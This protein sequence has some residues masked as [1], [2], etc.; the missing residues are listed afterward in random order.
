MAVTYKSFV[1]QIREKH[2]LPDNLPDNTV[3]DYGKKAYPGVSVDMSSMPNIPDV[4]DSPN[5]LGHL[6]RLGASADFAPEWL[7]HGY[8]NSLQGVTEKYMTG[9]LPFELED[10]WE[11]LNI[12]EQ[13]LSMIAS[14]TMPMDLMTML[15]GGAI[16]RIAVGSGKALTKGLVQ[17]GATDL[18]KKGIRRRI[19]E[20]GRKIGMK[21]A[22]QLA[23]DMVSGAAAE[24]INL[25]IYEGA[26]AGIEAS[27]QNKYNPQYKNTPINIL[28]EIGNGFTHGMTTGGILGLTGGFMGNKFAR[29][30]AAKSRYPNISMT[31]TKEFEKA[32][33]WYGKSG[34]WSFDPVGTGTLSLITA[35]QR[36]YDGDFQW[37]DLGRDLIV[38]SAF[39]YGTKKKHQALNKIVE[40]SGIKGWINKGVEEYKSDYKK[41]KESL[42]EELKYE[43]SIIDTFNEK[44]DRAE[45]Q[46]NK[47]QARVYRGVSEEL[48]SGRALEISKEIQKAQE[49]EGWMQRYSDLSKWYGG[50]EKVFDDIRTK[51]LKK[52]SKDTDRLLEVVDE[53][54]VLMAELDAIIT[55]GI[56]AGRYDKMDALGTLKKKYGFTKSELESIREDVTQISKD[57]FGELGERETSKVKDHQWYSD[58]IRLDKNLMKTFDLK[59]KD[60]AEMPLERLKDI[61]T[62]GQEATEGK[63]QVEAQLAAAKEG[64][65]LVVNKKPKDLDI[66]T[67]EYKTMVKEL[68]AIRSGKDKASPSWK[69]IRDVFTRGFRKKKGEP[70]KLWLEGV[71][72]FNLVALK[73][74]LQRGAEGKQ[75]SSKAEHVSKFLNYLGKLNKDVDTLTFADLLNYVSRRRV[76]LEGKAVSPTEMSA[77]SQF[78]K[79]ITSP[80]EG[81]FNKKLSFIGKESI[82]EATNKKLKAGTEFAVEG[83]RKEA[84]EIGQRLSK[85][86]AK[87]K[88]SEGYSLVAE[89]MAKLGIRDIEVSDIT[90]KQLKKDN[91]GRDYLDLKPSEIITD[92][93]TGEV[94]KKIGTAKADTIRRYVYV[95]KE[96][97]DRLNAFFEAGNKL[98]KKHYSTVGKKITKSKNKQRKQLDLRSR[99]ETEALIENPSV[100]EQLN[101]VLGHD[102]SRIGSGYRKMS[103]EKAIEIQVKLHKDGTLGVKTPKI[104]ETVKVK[105]KLGLEKEKPLNINEIDTP[106]KSVKYWEQ[107]QARVKERLKTATTESR[108]ETLQGQKLE[109]GMKLSA[110]KKL[111]EY[112]K[113]I[114]KAK[115]GKTKQN[116]IIERDKVIK[117]LGLQNVLKDVKKPEKTTP[118]DKTGEPSTP[119]ESQHEKALR[120]LNEGQQKHQRLYEENRDPRQKKIASEKDV[121]KKALKGSWALKGEAESLIKNYIKIHQDYAKRLKTDKEFGKKE[122]VGNIEYH[123]TWVKDYKEMLNVLK[124]GDSRDLQY[125]LED[126]DKL[127]IAD[128]RKKILQDAHIVQRDIGIGERQ[129]G[130]KEQYKKR[131]Q[132]DVKDVLGEDGVTSLS[133]LDTS[134]IIDYINHIQKSTSKENSNIKESLRSM[135]QRAQEAADEAQLVSAERADILKTINP[136][137]EGDFGSKYMNRET[138]KEYRAIVE[139]MAMNK[140]KPSTWS[141]NAM[142]M[143]GESFLKFP[144]RFKRTF[145]PA[146]SILK[147][148]GGKYGKKIADTLL[149]YDVV[150][151]LYRGKI[152]QAMY[153]VGRLESSFKVGNRHMLRFRDKSLRKDL[154]AEEKQFIKRMETKRTP[155]NTAKLIVDKTYNAYWNLIPNVIRKSGGRANVE[156]IEAYLGRKYLQDY[157][158]HKVNPLLLEV[159]ADRNEIVK[160]PFWKKK[161]NEEM[162][163]FARREAK[164]QGFSKEKDAFKYDQ[165]IRDIKLDPK[166][167][168]KVKSD[169]VSFF[170]KPMHQLDNPNLRERGVTLGRYTEILTPSGRIKK[171]KSYNETLEGTFE[172]YGIG[173]SKYLAALKFFPE[174]TSLGREFGLQNVRSDLFDMVSRKGK[175]SLNKNWYDYTAELIE[176]HLGF[177]SRLKRSY[178]EKDNRRMGVF[179]TTSAA[180]GLATPTAGLKNMFLGMTQTM[181]KYGFMNTINASMKFF[182]AQERLMARRK[183]WYQY[184]TKENVFEATESYFQEIPVFGKSL[185]MD[186]MFW[187]MTKSEGFNRFVAGKAGEL[188]F[189]ELLN[190]YKGVKGITNLSKKSAERELKDVLKFSKEELNHM[191]ENSLEYLYSKDNSGNMNWLINKAGHYGH[192]STQGGTAPVLLPLWMSRKAAKPFTLFY[193]IAASTTHNTYNNF[194]KPLIKDGNIMPIIKFGAM[195]GLSGATLYSFYDYILGKEEPF[196]QSDKN[197]IMTKILPYLWRGEFFGVFGE[198]FNP[199][200]NWIN[201]YG[202][203][204]K[205]NSHSL[206][207]ANMFEPVILRNSKLLLNQTI[208]FANGAYDAMDDATRSLGKLKMEQ[209]LK[210]VLFQGIVP[211]GQINRLWKNKDKDYES[212]QR[213]RTATRSFYNEKGYSKPSM[214]IES[215]RSPF[216]RNMKAK[217]W[218]GSE[219]EFAKTYWAAHAYIMSELERDGNRNPSSRNKLAKRYIE[220]S[221]KSFDPLAISDER[222]NRLFS[223]REEFLNYLDSDMRSKAKELSRKYKKRLGYLLRT[224]NKYRRK[225]SAMP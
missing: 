25:G 198:F 23:D 90:R 9:E 17:K 43:E 199:Y 7:K 50:N 52:D 63:I 66:K 76:E 112:N 119:H 138:M 140:G 122:G 163:S 175:D 35:G 93:G 48:S 150:N 106:E 80:I 14:F 2:N 216:Y 166:S 174:F 12:P 15:G 149:D 170:S 168:G 96:L 172:A 103:P 192:V 21:N 28:E 70:K 222:K 187:F 44:A 101:Y 6:A 208:K 54:Q 86:R 181:S 133:K 72:E 202:K 22:G 197:V 203:E 18:A 179:T 51:K 91:K 191:K 104:K 201:M 152:S 81:K 156:K 136:K 83:V 177:D 126:Y 155:E 196:S 128:R 148:M 19:S 142:S 207:Q 217:F 95:P 147:N 194:V 180:A 121:V 120:K 193:R 62:R 102:I 27:Y 219:K 82:F 79:F 65:G 100:M 171:V 34:K 211:A 26:K 173:M 75:L 224:S 135:Y 200:N 10:E 53:Q 124:K 160:Q 153:E 11:D 110:S 64:K 184:G 214:F 46:G 137:T 88:N 30:K 69:I 74:F 118:K 154:T 221:L 210:D 32:L 85:E 209:A 186:R 129:L 47:A 144:G 73:E 176:A 78:A 111:I 24:A 31:T 40:K 89:L 183:G 115:E 185:S 59:S 220:S 213:I 61:Y 57:I 45:A 60:L 132:Q 92:I 71:S 20:E 164:K 146:Y 29:L 182:D 38:N 94:I 157:M 205:F 39:M 188:Y 206:T 127:K 169:I 56:K 49:S 143:L 162:D 105:E 87:E 223:K 55:E 131:L 1:E 4:D 33:K 117:Q 178:G 98:E 123:D 107:Q 215:E 189:S 167:Q 139:E 159:L 116:L 165:K 36:A 8:A 134:Q 158:T 16:G 67:S 13:A 204:L 113:K 68:K 84:V 141:E 218:S 97:A 195:S 190:A 145:I 37:E 130:S 151:S 225:Y 114:A 42:E 125:K 3:F 161:F 99:I 58:T 41:K 5:G 212:H 77:L 109:A 108:R